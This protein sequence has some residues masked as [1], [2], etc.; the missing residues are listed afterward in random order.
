MKK[1]ILGKKHTI[2]IFLLCSESVIVNIDYQP[3]WTE[4]YQEIRH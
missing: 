3:D 2:E 1:V 4:Q